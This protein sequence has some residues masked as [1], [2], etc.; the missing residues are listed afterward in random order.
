MKNKKPR[1]FNR[2]L[3]WIEFNRRVL[4]EAGRKEN[5]P[6]ERLKFLAIVSSNFDEFFM[7][8][9]AGLKHQ[10]RINPNVPDSTGLTPAEQLYHISEH[11][12]AIIS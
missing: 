12:H 9:V 3:S 1:F 7:V 2:E 4:G 5:P 6:L 11:V 8:R 10:Q